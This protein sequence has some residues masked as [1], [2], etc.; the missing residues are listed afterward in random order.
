MRGHNIK[1]EY[2]LRIIHVVLSYLKPRQ[3]TL[4]GELILSMSCRSLDKYNIPLKNFFL[5]CPHLFS[6]S[7]KYTTQII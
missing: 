1:K 7:T 6:K 4:S 2:G 5:S 3:R